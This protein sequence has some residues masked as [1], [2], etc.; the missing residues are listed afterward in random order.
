MFVHPGPQTRS[1]AAIFGSMLAVAAAAAFAL[2]PPSAAKSPTATGRNTSDT[3][4]VVDVIQIKGVISPITHE[5]IRNAIES[6]AKARRAALVLEIDTPGGLES[7]MRSI[8]QEILKSPVPVIAWVAPSGAHAASAGLYLVTASHVAAMA[9]NTNLGAA[10]PISMAG[11]MDSTLKA[12]ATNDA[13]ALIETLAKERGRNVE[14]NVAAVRNAIAASEKEALEKR[15]I[16]FVASDVDDV[17]RK[18]DGRVVRLPS[19][20]TT[21]A[22]AGATANRIAPTF[23]VKILSTIADPTVAYILFNLGTLGLVFEL[24]NPG[25]ILPGVAGA[26]CIV[27]ALIA[28]QT[29][30]VNLGGLLLLLLAVVF[31]LIELKVSSHGILAAGGVLAFVAGSL[32]LFDPAAGPAFRVSVGVIAST[33]LTVAAF[34]LFAVGAGVRAQKRRTTTG[35]EGLVGEVGTA[36]SRCAPEAP[37]QARVRGEIWRA[38]PDDGARPIEPGEGVVVIRVEGLTARVA[39]RS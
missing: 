8:V 33:A 4:R 5:Q 36:L 22:L 28:F 16:D 23:R 19:G 18:S 11:P 31:F 34:F 13:A 32:L 20:E 3:A 1:S 30:P 37:G 17:I 2:A 39:P 6:A 21:L 7:S 24:S 38:V 26:I 10:T 29:L 27:L 12:K 35:S 25:A 15:V 14:W 9:P